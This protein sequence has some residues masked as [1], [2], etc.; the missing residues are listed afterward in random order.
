MGLFTWTHKKRADERHLTRSDWFIIMNVNSYKKIYAISILLALLLSPTALHAAEGT[1]AEDLRQ[2]VLTSYATQTA[3]SNTTSILAYGTAVDLISGRKGRLTLYSLPQGSMRS[4]ILYISAVDSHV[5]RGALTSYTLKKGK[6][7]RAKH[8]LEWLIAFEQKTLAVPFELMRGGLEFEHSGMGFYGG[9]K[10]EK[11]TI[12]DSSAPA[13][14]VFIDTLTGQPVK[15]I[16]DSG[17]G[18]EGQFRMEFSSYAE[19]GQW[20]LP[21]HFRLLRAGK[22]TLEITIEDYTF[23][24][25]VS[26]LLFS[27]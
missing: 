2:R 11:L 26:P 18:A 16:M 7:I 20:I 12:Y 24:T 17:Y 1:K 22:P 27:P 6:L 25:S 3:L 21:H 15:A 5:R 13:I 4:D 10:Y 14:I 8:E 23:N 9:K 19:D